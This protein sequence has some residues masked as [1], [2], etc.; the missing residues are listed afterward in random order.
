MARI[1]IITNVYKPGN[2]YP[3]LRANKRINAPSPTLALHLYQF[4][5]IGNVERNCFV[6]K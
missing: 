3:W 1:V 6:L 4:L 2:K 5:A